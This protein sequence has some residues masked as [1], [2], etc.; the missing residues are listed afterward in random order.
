[1][2]RPESKPIL[3][4]IAAVLA[5]ESA[6]RLKIEGHTDAT[7]SSVHNLDLSKR[8]AEAVRGYLVGKAIDGRRLET[9]GLGAAQPLAPN[10]TDLGRA[11]NRRV[12]LVR[13]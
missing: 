8:R 6:W 9:V 13:L 11:Q 10:E 2:I 3:D 7:G 4:K 5:A 1:V 12:E